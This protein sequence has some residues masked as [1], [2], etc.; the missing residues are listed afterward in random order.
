METKKRSGSSIGASSLLV[1]IVVVSLVCFATLS[2]TSASA[3]L[4]LSQK[5]ADR[6]SSYY[7]ACNEA[8]NTLKNLSGSF[9]SI[10][11]ESMNEDEYNQ[12]I[13]ESLSDSLTFTYPMNE[14]QILQVSISPLYP[15]DSSGD[16]FQISSWQIVNTTSPELDESLP[17]FQKQ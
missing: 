10:Y 3:D 6:T 14:N 11:M 17:V 4:R 7:E 13:K 12:K 2:I 8:Q 16:F 5:L 9:R 15:Q 1:I